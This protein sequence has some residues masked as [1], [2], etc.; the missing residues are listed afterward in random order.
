[1]SFIFQ[2]EV[3]TWEIFEYCSIYIRQGRYTLDPVF[4]FL[5]PTCSP[6]KQCL[7]LGQEGPQPRLTLY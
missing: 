1:M 7:R 6:L 4:F 5:F 2:T 3:L